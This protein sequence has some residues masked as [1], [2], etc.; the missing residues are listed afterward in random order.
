[1]RGPQIWTLLRQRLWCPREIPLR[2]SEEWRT[3][4]ASVHHDFL[5][6]NIL[7]QAS[8]EVIQKHL[9]IVYTEPNSSSIDVDN[10]IKGPVQELT[11]YLRVQSNILNWC[12]YS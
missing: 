2:V 1:M 5:I 4:S 3:D 9:C 6:P 8:R 12:S 10:A 7:R 11:K